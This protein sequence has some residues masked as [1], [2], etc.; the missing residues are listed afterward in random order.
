MTAIP[1]DG[2][3]GDGWT[4]G[5]YFVSATGRDNDGAYIIV[6]GDGDGR[7]R[8]GTADLQV[9]AKRGEAWRTD[10]PEALANGH[11]FA[12]A[13][14]LYA[15]LKA[16]EWKDDECCPFCGVHRSSP[17]DP[18]LRLAGHAPNCDVS[19]ALARARGTP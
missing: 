6:A 18:P 2:E 15:A 4:K 7:K 19:A 9:K 1:K 17:T 13:P 11:L 5:P 14:E 8:I 12:A 10:D 16:V 3:R